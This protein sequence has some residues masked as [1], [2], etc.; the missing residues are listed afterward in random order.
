MRGAAATLAIALALAAAACGGADDRSTAG[1]VLQPSFV[2]QRPEFEAIADRLYAG[3]N[4]YLGQAQIASHEARLASPDLVPTARIE[5]LAELAWHHARLGQLPPA[6]ERIDAALALATT[7]DLAPNARAELWFRAG[8]VFLREAE[9]QNCI[10]RHNPDCCIF[11]LA[12]GGVHQVAQPALR[13]REA[14]ERY[15]E[16]RP[17]DLGAA[18]LLN[19][20]AMAAGDYPRGVPARHQ[21]P[22]R[23][24]ASGADP[25]KFVDVAPRVGLDVLNNAG[26]VIAD[27]LDG[28]G[29]LDVVTS[30][31]DPRGPLRYLRNLGDGRFEDRSAASRLDD[32]L[33]GLNIVGA[34]YDDDGDLDILVLRGAWLFEDGRMRKSLLRNEGDGTFSDVTREAGLALPERPTQTAAWGDYDNDGDLD[35]Y[36]GCESPAE[37]PTRYPSQLFRN[38][39]DGTFT[40]VAEAAGVLNHAFAKGV[41][42]GDYDD[43]GD[44][45]LYVSNLG[46]NRLYRNDGGMKFVDV[47]PELGLTRP[48]GRSFASWFFDHDNDGDLDLWVGAYDATIK[49]VYFDTLGRQHGATPPCLYRNDGGGR[50]TDVARESGLDHAWLPM[51]ANFGDL[52]N[53]GWLDVYLGTGD[54]LFVS[55]MPNVMLRNDAGRRFQNVTTAT[56]T[57]HLQKGHGIAFADFDHDG[58]QDVFHQLGGFYPGDRFKNALFVNPGHG[59]HW[60]TIELRGTTTNA[61]AVGVRLALVLDTPAGRRTIHRAVGSV[62]SFGGSP[63]RQEIGLGAASVVAEL[64]VR[65]PTSGTRQVFRDVPAD[66]TILVVEGEERYE[67]LARPRFDLAVER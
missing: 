2:P 52:D 11:P 47:A 57:G 61:R 28:D 63:S 29:L 4:K 33:G 42:A 37:E 15:L 67:R 22:P 30:N 51:G 48:D 25:G 49:N 65:W 19:V 34:D 21:I 10:V 36:V 38:D 8:V 58:D 3:E 50:F 41:A 46:P 39:G 55:L 6:I 14:F 43:D 27:D 53:D 40:D 20:I 13:A 7:T 1:A 9:V 23:A 45:D 32:Q 62:S 17:D 60:L 64:E 44:L 26:G 5:A 54:P 66:G 31:F 12:G 16:L 56:G 59:A 35:V 18:W 24:F